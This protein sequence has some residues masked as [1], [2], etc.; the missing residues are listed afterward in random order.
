MVRRGSILMAAALWAAVGISAA[1]S[2]KIARVI[3]PARWPT[4]ASQLAKDQV[5]A[6]SALAD[7]IRQNQDFQLLDPSEASDRIPVPLW[8]RIVWRKAHPELI[9]SVFAPR[10]GYPHVL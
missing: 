1:Q 5:P 9:Y 3:E 6:S 10:C 8:L 4:L 7:L 2:Q